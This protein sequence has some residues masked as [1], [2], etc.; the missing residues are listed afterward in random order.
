MILIKCDMEVDSCSL[1][2]CLGGRGG[3]QKYVVRC[4]VNHMTN[5]TMIDL[6]ATGGARSYECPPNMSWGPSLSQQGNRSDYKYSRLRRCQG[7]HQMPPTYGHNT[8]YKT[9]YL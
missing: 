6:T 1:P 8:T 9:V 4:L 2:G 7:V 3:K 5:D